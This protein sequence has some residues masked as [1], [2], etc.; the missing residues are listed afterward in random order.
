MIC[1][2]S[3]LQRRDV[4]CLQDGARLGTVGDVEIDTASA[5][6]SAVVVY[7]RPRFLGLF[8]RPQ[9]L[10]VPWEEISLL[11]S[12]TILVKTR[13]VQQWKTPGAVSRFFGCLFTD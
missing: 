10:L 7:G 2:I 13:P 3:D 4:I 9:P 1:R 11:G 12:D 8:G 6:M 5:K